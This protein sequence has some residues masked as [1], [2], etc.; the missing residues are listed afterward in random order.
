VSDEAT[1]TAAGETA[2]V[3]PDRTEP[4]QY[5]VGARVL[6]VELAREFAEILC[7]D[8]SHTVQSA[9]LEAGLRPSTVR[10]AL[11]RYEHDACKTLADEE[12]C[13]LVYRA[14][15]VH[16]KD[17]NHAGYV[18]AGTKNKAGTSWAQWQLEV[19]SPLE[20]PRKQETTLEVTG[21]DGG[22]IQTS[23]AIRYVVTV[24]QEERDERDEESE[25]QE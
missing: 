18:S 17:I 13:E 20:Y 10:D 1:K 15:S 3:A 16:I 23:N 6:T 9:A 2:L 4:R 11:M 5:R 14:K 24:P 25:R 12:V 22:P 21:K 8:L 7:S 19:Q